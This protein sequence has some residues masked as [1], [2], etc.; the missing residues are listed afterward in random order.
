M[1]SANCLAALF[2]LAFFGIAAH[3]V[4]NGQTRSN[5]TGTGGVNQIRGRIYLPNGKSIDDSIS[6]ELQSTTFGSLT[7]QTDRS[8]SFAFGGLNPGTYAV[9]VNVG[10]SF[11]I[12]REYVTIDPEVQTSTIRV[13]S[14]PKTFTVPI[15]LQRK[16]GVVLR[17]DVIQA[18][19]STIPKAAIEKVKHGMELQQ[20]RKNAEAE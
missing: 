3:V 8:G 10:D 20:E 11:E 15:Y 7:V 19:W 14:I 2:V 4:V 1:R 6:V 9:V 12:V 16:R 17:N 18:K 5:S 13:P